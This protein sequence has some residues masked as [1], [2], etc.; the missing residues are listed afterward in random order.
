MPVALSPSQCVSRRSRLQPRKQGVSSC[1]PGVILSACVIPVN[2][3][4][5]MH[6]IVLLVVTHHWSALDDFCFTMHVG[7]R[8]TS[9]S[10]SALTH[11]SAVYPLFMLNNAMASFP[12]HSR[13]DS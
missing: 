1:L 4:F 9:T 5:V 11:S 13:G 2:A 6:V 10:L 12:R 8:G 3:G 7:I